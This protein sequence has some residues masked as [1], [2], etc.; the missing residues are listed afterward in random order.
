MKV[1]GRSLNARRGRRARG[2]LTVI[3][4]VV[5]LSAAIVGYFLT[6]G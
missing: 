2:V 1:T 4:G 3:T 5:G 6:L